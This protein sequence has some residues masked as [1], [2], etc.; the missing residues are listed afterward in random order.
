MS[1]TTPPPPTANISQTCS[2]S[3]VTALNQNQGTLIA[4]TEHLNGRID[5]DRRCTHQT[6][7]SQHERVDRRNT[8]VTSDEAEQDNKSVPATSGRLQSVADSGT[9]RRASNATVIG[10]SR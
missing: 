4:P 1:H 2:P 3:L 5:P 8:V 9:A 7:L 6:P 10:A